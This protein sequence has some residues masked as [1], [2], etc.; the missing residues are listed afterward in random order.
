MR[1]LVAS[2]V[3]LSSSIV[4]LVNSSDD[5][6]RVVGNEPFQAQG[7]EERKGMGEERV[8]RFNMKYIMS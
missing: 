8:N 3:A 2:A 7:T 6:I 1:T 4:F 5:T